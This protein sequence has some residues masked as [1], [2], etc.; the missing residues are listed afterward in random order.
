VILIRDE[1][2]VATILC[3]MQHVQP[4]V[5][6]AFKHFERRMHS[7]IARPSFWNQASDHCPVYLT[8]TPPTS[9]S[10]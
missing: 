6:L 10:R 4:T 7:G 8:I 9:G 1:Y 3:A 2:Y 5:G